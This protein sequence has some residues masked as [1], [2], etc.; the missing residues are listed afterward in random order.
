MI[1]RTLAVDYGSRRVGLAVCDALGITTRPLHTIDR[2]VSPDVV[3]SVCACA[4]AEAVVRVIVGIPRLASGDA[5][6]VA[7][8]ARALASALAAALAGEGIDVLEVDEDDTSQEAARRLATERGGRGPRRDARGRPE[9]KGAIDAAAAA[10]LL[11]T[12]LSDRAATGV[13]ND[14]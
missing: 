12:W 14:R 10:V 8:P 7:A 13:W 4:R 6:A 9:D 3:A 11:E 1:G 5:G 2:R